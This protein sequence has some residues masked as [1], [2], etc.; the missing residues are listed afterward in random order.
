MSIKDHP[1]P[2]RLR[3]E[4]P[5]RDQDRL[6]DSDV[7]RMRQVILAAIREEPRRTWGTS[8]VLAA[9]MVAVVCAGVWV[10]R[11]P[12]PV[13]VSVADTSKG[14]GPTE[15]RSSGVRQMQFSTPGGTRVIWVFDASFEMR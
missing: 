3:A 1:L 14:Q 2:D 15:A 6:A 12:A 13:R 10:V 8:M 11:E 9:A 5:W 7:R 4:D